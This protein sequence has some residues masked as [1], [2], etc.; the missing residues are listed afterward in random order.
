MREAARYLGLKTVDAKTEK[1][2]DEME[3]EADT[4]APS[5]VYACFSATETEDGVSLD[6]TGV[7]LKGKLAKKHFSGCGKVIVVL[8]TLGLKSEILLKRTFALSAAK[9]VVLDAV[10]TEKIES[11]LDKIEEKLASEYGK[12]TGRISC[13]YGDLPISVQKDLFKLLEGG[14]IGVGMNECFMLTPNKS[15]IALIGVR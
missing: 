13:G 11:Y 8:A 1:L 7:L 10:Y 9:A 2:I 6:G 12:I 4:L 14:K 5:Y 3:R 15:V